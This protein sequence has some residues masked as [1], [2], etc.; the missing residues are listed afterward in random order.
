MSSLNPTMKCIDQLREVL[1]DGKEILNLFIEITAQSNILF[2]MI[3]FGFYCSQ[4]I[5][6]FRF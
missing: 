6:Y 4:K 1:N 3:L 2:A 5:A